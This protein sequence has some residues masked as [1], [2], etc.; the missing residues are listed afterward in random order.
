MV[1]LKDSKPKWVNPIS[2]IIRVNS[3]R[4]GGIQSYISKIVVRI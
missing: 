3:L 2:D 1:K 4:L